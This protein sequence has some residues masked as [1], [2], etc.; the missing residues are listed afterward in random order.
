MT[1]L[2]GGTCSIQDQPQLVN[3]VSGRGTD[4]TTLEVKASEGSLDLSGAHEDLLR[5]P[6]ASD[7]AKLCI[8]PRYCR[9]QW[10]LC[11]FSPRRCAKSLSDL[12]FSTERIS[13]SRSKVPP[14]STSIQPVEMAAPQ[15]LKR[16]RETEVV[17]RAFIGARCSDDSPPGAWR[18]AAAAAGVDGA[19]AFL[20]HLG[21]SVARVQSGPNRCLGRAV[22]TEARQN[23]RHL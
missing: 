1:S 10:A 20:C 17:A 6:V 22:S 18:A 2:D 15:A 8:R 12:H 3:A 23:W 7:A 16:Q 11:V 5:H 4:S 14:S 19:D 9:C 21:R 13:S